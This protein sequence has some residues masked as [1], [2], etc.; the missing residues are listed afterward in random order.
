LP[1]IKRFWRA[2]DAARGFCCGLE[3]AE[4]SGPLRRQTWTRGRSGRDG[5]SKARSSCVT[6]KG[7]HW[8]AR[9]KS[10]ELIRTPSTCG[11]KRQRSCGEKLKRIVVL[12]LTS[13]CASHPCPAFA[14]QSARDGGPRNRST[15]KHSTAAFTRRKTSEE[16]RWKFRYLKT[17]FSLASLFLK[18][19]RTAGKLRAVFVRQK[20]AGRLR[21]RF[22]GGKR[23]AVRRIV[24]RGRFLH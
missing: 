13:P 12:R 4:G 1:G 5:R 24:R 7:R 14:W 8:S 18:L 10:M 6:E 11:A 20:Q 17:N 21:G 16:P 22:R 19:E 23:V 3:H 9:I 15:S 2:V